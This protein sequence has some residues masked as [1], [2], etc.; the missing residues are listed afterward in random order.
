MRLVLDILLFLLAWLGAVVLAAGGHGYL[1]TLPP[2]AAIVLHVVVSRTRSAAL[3]VIVLAG[4]VGLVAE[5]LLLALGFTSYAGHVPTT[6]APPV[7]VIALWASFG[8]LHDVTH[9]A[10]RGEGANV[11]ALGALAG[12][13][14]YYAGERLGAI[15]LAEPL[16]ITYLVL[17]AIW[18]LAAPLLT[19][20]ARRAVT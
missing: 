8:I 16:W 13:V 2:L 7:W 12:P 4:V 14:A 9:A 20:A 6:L 15:T 19:A 3:G 5:S 10:M 11:A 17:M 1:A 18:A